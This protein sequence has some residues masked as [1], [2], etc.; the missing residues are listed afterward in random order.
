MSVCEEDI[1]HMRSYQYHNICFQIAKDKKAFDVY[2]RNVRRLLKRWVQ[3][4]LV[5]LFMNTTRTKDFLKK[6]NHKS[7]PIWMQLYAYASK[8]QYKTLFQ[9]NHN[10]S[11]RV[12]KDIRK[13]D[14]VSLQKQPSQVRLFCIS[15]WKRANLT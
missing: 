6:V 4:T 2:H 10:V 8:L 11:C 7:S 15:S 13:Y 3:Q 9:N 1:S 14:N 12:S 5:R